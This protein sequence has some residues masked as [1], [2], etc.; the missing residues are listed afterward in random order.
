MVENIQG[1]N[2]IK[3]VLLANKI[4]DRDGGD[5]ECLVGGVS[6]FLKKVNGFGIV[7]HGSAAQAHFFKAMT[8]VSPV[9]ANV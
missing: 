1:E 8:E 3:G 4:K 2:D 6:E 7:F 9:G 5:G